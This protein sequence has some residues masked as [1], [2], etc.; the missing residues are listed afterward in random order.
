VMTQR[1]IRQA[2]WEAR[3]DGFCGCMQAMKELA[4]ERGLNFFE[5][6]ETFGGQLAERIILAFD[7]PPITE[8]HQ[9]LLYFG[10]INPAHREA[11]RAWQAAQ[12]P[13]MQEFMSQYP[14]AFV[15]VH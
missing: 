7:E 4:D 1:I 12:Q 3:W 13:L 2:S 5:A 15:T 10:S 11:S 8:L 14:H 6:C 9:A